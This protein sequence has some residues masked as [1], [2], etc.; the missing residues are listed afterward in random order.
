MPGFQ[1]RLRLPAET[2]KEIELQGISSPEWPAF[3]KKFSL[4]HGRE[5]E[6]YSILL[7]LIK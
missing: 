5:L 2:M 4:H 3:L 6:P 1:K 7:L